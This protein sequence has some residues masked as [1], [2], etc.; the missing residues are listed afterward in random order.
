M[1]SSV[2]QRGYRRDATTAT[3]CSRL[4]ALEFGY[5]EAVID[6]DRSARSTPAALENLPAG[7]DGS[8]YRWVDLDGEG[9]SGVLT[10][11][12]G[13]WFYKPNLGDGRFGAAR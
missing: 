8:R 11:Q 4:P 2:T 10:E 6:D 9:L 1:S 5:S 13:A 3:S 7:V 12:A